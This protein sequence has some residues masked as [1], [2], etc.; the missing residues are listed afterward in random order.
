MYMEPAGKHTMCVGHDDT[1]LLPCETLP[2]G[3]SSTAWQYNLM[4]LPAAVQTLTCQHNLARHKDE[5]HNLWLLHAVDQ[6]RE[7]LWFILQTT[8]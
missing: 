6:T 5:K 1:L 2:H 7:Q 8:Q 4:I 3:L